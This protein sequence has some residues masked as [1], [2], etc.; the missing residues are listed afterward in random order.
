MGCKETTAS[1]IIHKSYYEIMRL[2]INLIFHKPSL[3]LSFDFSIPKIGVLHG[4]L[5][6]INSPRSFKFSV[7]GF[8]PSLNFQ[9]VLLLMWK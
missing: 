3:H 2:F 1:F 6:G 7:M 4:L 8:N 9:W 5:Q